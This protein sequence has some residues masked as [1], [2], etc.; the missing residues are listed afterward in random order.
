MTGRPAPPWLAELQQR[1]GAVLTVPLGRDTGTLTA[2]V[3]AYAPEVV[4]DVRDAHNATAAARLAVYNRQYWFRLF[5]VMQTGYP[6]TTRLLGAWRFNDHAARFLRA[7]PPRHW[8]IDR[9]LDGFEASLA[10]TLEPGPERDACLE[11]ARLE[12]LRRALFR[13]PAVPTFAPTAADAARLLDARLV[14][15]PAVAIFRESFA[16][17]TLDASGP[18]GVAPA[19]LP[20]PRWWALVRGPSGVRYDALAPLEGELLELLGRH[21]VREALARL[22]A[23]CTEA[24][25]AALPTHAQRWLAQSVA[26]GCWVGLS[27]EA[28]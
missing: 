15:S 17:V 8:D 12:S 5:T 6:L 24:E 7:R 20:R 21:T 3:D 25:R 18:E 16:L 13:A 19:R 27:D 14:P 10:E 28:G 4:A 23:S 26:R 2:P 1:F 9:A 22:E 11:A